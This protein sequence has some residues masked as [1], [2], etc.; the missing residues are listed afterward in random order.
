VDVLLVDDIQFL[1]GKEGTQEEFFHTFNALHQLNKQIVISSDRP[2]KAIQ[3]LEHRLLSRFEWGMIADINPPNLETRIAILESKCREKN[4]HL[5][6]EVIN[7]LANVIQNNI[8]ELEGA[9][10]RI[11]AYHQLN[12]T[13]PTVEAIKPILAHIISPAPK[14]SLTA[15]Q[16]SSVIA[17]YFDIKQEELYGSCRKKHLTLPRQIAM[18]LMRTE[19]NSSYPSI[20]AEFSGRDHTTAIHAFE[21][22]Q[23]E[24]DNDAKLNQD[25]NLIKQRLYNL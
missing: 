16:I 13:E 11:I 7:Y 25:V 15:K 4:F 19:L 1:S 10:N 12:K 20:G 22:I 5:S 18:Y 8:R 6:P 24:L 21:K 9:L 17:D 2:P 14:K 23:K 3:A